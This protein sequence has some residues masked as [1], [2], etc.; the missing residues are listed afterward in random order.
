M[1]ATHLATRSDSVRRLRSGLAA[2]REPG[3][4]DQRMLDL[5]LGGARDL[6]RTLP[7]TDQRKLDEYLDSV[8]SVE[9]RIAATTLGQSP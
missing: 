3:E 6:R 7:V 8:R 5:V 9:R 4:L 1:D 2:R